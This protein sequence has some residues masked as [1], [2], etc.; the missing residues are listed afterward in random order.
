MMPIGFKVKIINIT[1]ILGYLTFKQ[2]KF[3]RTFFFNIALIFFNVRFQV[4][5][6][7]HPLS[8]FYS[9]CFIFSTVYY[10]S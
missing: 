3:F 4:P 10:R 1:S 7:L 8:S 2:Q 6:R 9:S 5:K